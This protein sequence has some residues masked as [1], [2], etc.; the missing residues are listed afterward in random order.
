VFFFNNTVITHFHIVC[1]KLVIQSRTNFRHN[2]S[3]GVVAEAK[4]KAQARERFSYK[5]KSVSFSLTKCTLLE[6]VVAP[7]SRGTVFM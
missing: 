4:M 2:L 7:A 3:N 6:Y 1:L 5:S